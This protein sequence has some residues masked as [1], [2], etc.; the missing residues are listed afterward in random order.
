MELLPLNLGCGKY[1]RT[2]ALIAGTVRPEGIDLKCVP[3]TTQPHDLFTKVLVGGE[4]DAAEMSLSNLTTLIGRGDRSLIGIPVFLSRTFRHSFI[5]VNAGAGITKPQDLIGRRVGVPEYTMT[6]AVWIRA[7]LQHDFGVL[8][9]QLK[10]FS[11][12]LDQ[13]GRP[14]RIK[15]ELPEGVEVQAIPAG[16]SLGAMLDAGQLDALICAAVPRVFSVGS[17]RVT[18]LFPDY[19]RVEAD[20]YARTGLVPIMHTVVIRRAVYEQFPWVARSLYEAFDRAKDEGYRWLEDTGAPNCSLTWLQAYLE[21]ERAIFGL[22]HWPYGL[23]ANRQSVEALASYV[24]EQGLSER[25][26]PVESIF[27]KETLDLG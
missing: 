23:T 24:Y 18:R 21:E 2:Q 8:P 5:F 26:V 13:P 6:A 16:A 15:V 14:E 7:F 10:W 11:G 25:L 12:G 27:A 9:R 3:N 4:F 22:D 1:D 17:P 19:R 20:Y